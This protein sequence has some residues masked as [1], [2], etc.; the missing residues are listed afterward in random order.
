VPLTSSAMVSVGIFYFILSWNNF[1]WPYIAITSEEHMVL[2]AALPTFLSN[3][4]LLVNNIMAASAIA[5]IPAM[6]VFIVLQ[7]NIVQGVAMT[8]IKG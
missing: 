1:I 3:N 5:A 2:A 7:K 6:A 8:G 4:T